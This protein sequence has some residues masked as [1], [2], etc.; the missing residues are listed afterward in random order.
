MF[1]DPL[2]TPSFAVN[3]F[4]ISLASSIDSDLFWSLN[5][6]LL[7][8]LIRPRPLI[9]IGLLHWLSSSFIGLLH[10]LSS[11]Y[12]W[13][14]PT[15]TTHHH[16]P[17]PLIL[18]VISLAS[19]IDCHRHIIGLLHWLSSSYHWPP[20]LILIVISLASSGLDHSS[21]L[22]SYIDFIV[23]SL[24]SSALDHSSSLASYIDQFQLRRRPR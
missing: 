4:V 17:P 13:P 19:S 22:A 16:W 1:T 6:D 11:S 3:T 9:I 5:S 23:I 10:W 2:N 15:S 24:A 8:S 18:I 21:S 14:P 7:C 20:P 12:H